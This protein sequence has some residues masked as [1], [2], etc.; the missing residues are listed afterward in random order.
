MSLYFSVSLTL[1]HLDFEINSNSNVDD[2]CVCVCDVVSWCHSPL[3][4]EWIT[5][6]K[7]L[8]HTI[9]TTLLW[10][11]MY[12]IHSLSI[13]FWIQYFAFEVLR[14]FCTCI[15]QRMS[16]NIQNFCRHA[17]KIGKLFLEYFHNHH[18]QLTITWMSVIWFKINYLCY[19]IYNSIE[20]ISSCMKLNR[21]H[22]HIHFSHS[23][24]IRI[25]YVSCILF[26]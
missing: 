20:F 13:S 7:L 14:I 26:F 8:H 4:P 12:A 24:C 17:Q 10:C 18:H 22:L 16:E 11:T 2:M 1:F 5:S 9:L 3:Y 21:L 19:S 15:K 23:F 6:Q 25:V